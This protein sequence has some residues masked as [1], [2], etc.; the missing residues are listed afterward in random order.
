MVPVKAGIIIQRNLWV[1]M[2]YDLPFFLIIRLGSHPQPW[3]LL[4]KG[5]LIGHDSGASTR[6]NR[7]GKI[8]FWRIF[9]E[10][11]LE[12]ARA[13]GLTSPHRSDHFAAVLLVSPALDRLTGLFHIFT[14][15]VGGSA[16]GEGR[17]NDT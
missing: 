10:S 7:V 11:I 4:P 1:C 17:D 15:T 6:H 13:M 14:E 5:Q 3:G 2:M 12:K 8:H 16:A 9:R